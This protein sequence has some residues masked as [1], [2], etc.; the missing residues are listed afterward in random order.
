MKSIRLILAAVAAVTAGF[1]TSYHYSGREVRQLNARVHELELER[2]RLVAYA[3]RL[4]A[5]R[6]VAQLDVLEQQ[7]SPDG[8]TRTVVRW[9]QIGPDG[10]LGVPEVISIAG[11]QVYVE[12]LVIKF[13]HAHVG[14]G[15]PG[16][17]ASLALFRRIFGEQQ[18]PETGIPLDQTAPVERDADPATRAAHEALW[19][20]FWEL[21][22]DPRLADQYG[23]RVA[24]I[25]APSARVSAGD[26]WE[27][28][29][30]AAGGLNLKKMAERIGGPAG[31]RSG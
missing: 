4:S 2:G 12:A 5:E 30:D 15:T 18:T 29:V 22:A 31:R 10:E 1:V 3:E 6:R 17:D 25:E 26:I 24:Q 20:R 21:A 7:A 19:R 28:S 23:V 13:E 27:V 8:A 16:R 14:E 11:G 9:Q